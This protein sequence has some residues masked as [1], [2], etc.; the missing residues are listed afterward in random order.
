[1]AYL[2]SVT[3]ECQ[4]L[5]YL[6]DEQDTVFSM[7]KNYFM[8]EEGQSLFE[9]ILSLR[10]KNM[11]LSRENLL[12]EGNNRNE[13]INHE[14]L[15]AIYETDYDYGQWGNYYLVLREAY[16][17]DQIQNHLL[18]DVLTS[19]TTTGRLDIVKLQDFA[20]QLQEN[21]LT[22]QGANT[23]IMNLGQMFDVYEYALAR[24]QAGEYQ[25]R[26]GCKTL[27]AA[28]AVGFAPGEITT[29]FGSTGVG[30]STYA[31][32]L[33]NRQIN[34]RIP[35]LYISLEMSTVST[36]DR[37][38]AARTRI[39]VSILCSSNPEDLDDSI[40]IRVKK[41]REVLESVKTFYFV[42]DPSINMAKL[43]KIIIES[44]M[45]SKSKYMVVTID[46]L[47]MMPEFSGEDPKGYEKG[48][49]EL[50]RMA[51]RLG[52][53]FVVVVQA[54]QKTLEAHAPASI[55]GVG[56]FRPTLAS[57]KNSGAIA[58]RSRIVIGVFREKY[59]AS[60]LFPDDPNLDMMDDVLSA[61]ILKQSMGSV[62]KQIEYLHEEGTFRL[63][64]VP[65][66]YQPF[67]PSMS[68]ERDAPISRGGSH[69]SSDGQTPQR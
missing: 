30:K 53:H 7:D 66:G 47:T 13:N 67:V 69:D 37:L 26:T 34:R 15:D 32:Y 49:D 39:P 6:I 19:V 23:I 65:N 8:S 45:R 20:Y 2:A 18:K 63:F 11:S 28:L 40:L 31:L 21:I 52:V 27:D 16:A 17:Q 59:Y 1:M 54:V 24:R 68:L 44:Q 29:I 41:E 12:V 33:I 58:E 3:N 62:G 36:M 22:T 14:L 42:D 4:C 64:P 5:H 57:I 25:F 38:V 60:R 9:T 51:K 55:S 10:K 43:E 48:M 61:Q 46:L 35:S 50:H 56:V